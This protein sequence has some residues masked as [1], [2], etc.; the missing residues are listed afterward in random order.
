M[1]R[2]AE[3]SGVGVTRGRSIRIYLA[4]AT[5]TGIRHAELDNWTG[6]A[7]VCPRPLTNSLATWEETKRP[8]VYFLFGEPDMRTEVYIGET[9]NGFVRIKEHLQKKEFW[10]H[11]V[12]FSS[13]DANLTKTHVLYLEARLY[14]LAK[15]SGRGRVVNTRVPTTPQ[16]SRPE[17]D[18]MEEYLEH[19]GLLLGALGF[20]VLQTIPDEPS[21]D[22]DSLHA[23]LTLKRPKK[24][25][26]ASGRSTD[27][28]FV[29]FK[30]STAST[31]AVESLQLTYRQ[32]RQKLIS[33]GT[34]EE[35]D[36]VYVFT[37]SHP[38]TS[39]SAA[40][41]VV[42]GSSISGRE[43]WKDA[44][45]RSLRQLEEILAQDDDAEVDD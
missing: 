12:L 5:P 36:G 37:K 33:D 29:V 7:I 21:N 45:G 19:L 31:D 39:P 28:G 27:D 32:Q 20:S 9:E 16:L 43:V 24:P 4:D 26:R 8:C 11:A 3:R 30:G 35:R 40:A 42:T 25:E 15:E 10:R 17:I 38:F 34:M 23:T 1:G 44:E 13:K 18:A 41:A 2:R 22:E 14:A 6:Q